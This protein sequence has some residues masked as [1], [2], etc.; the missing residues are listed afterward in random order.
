MVD[1][2]LCPLV[3]SHHSISPRLSLSS[4]DTESL[5]HGECDVVLPSTDRKRGAAALE[6]VHVHVD[7][8]TFGGC[9][10][11][12][13]VDDIKTD[14]GQEGRVHLIIARRSIKNRIPF[15]IP[16]RIPKVSGH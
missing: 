11:S 10:I 3:L 7:L 15:R 6:Y 16:F 14:N 1:L 5:R 9:T 2:A 8:Y 13:F 4:G 12:D